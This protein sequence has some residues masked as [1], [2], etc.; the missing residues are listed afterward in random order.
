MLYTGFLPLVLFTQAGK[1]LPMIDTLIERLQAA[2]QVDLLAMTYQFGGIA[3]KTEPERLWFRGRFSMLQDILKESWV[4]QETIEQG[5]E[6]GIQ[7]GREQERQE[8][9]EGIA[10]LLL[11]AFQKRHE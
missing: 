1:T 6:Q 7:R 10:Q 9:E 3:F 4:Y 11:F 2:G 5:I 8:E